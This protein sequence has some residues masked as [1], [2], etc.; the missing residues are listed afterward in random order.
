MPRGRGI[1][2]QPFQHATS[3]IIMGAGNGLRL[4]T[5]PRQ[6]CI[7]H[8]VRA[9]VLTRQCPRPRSPLREFPPTRDTPRSA[10][11]PTDSEGD[12]PPLCGDAPRRHGPWHHGI[13]ARCG[14]SGKASPGI[15]SPAIYPRVDH[16]RSR[17]L[18][19]PGFRWPPSVCV[20]CLHCRPGFDVTND[21][22]QL[23]GT[24]RQARTHGSQTQRSHRPFCVAKLRPVLE[25]LPRRRDDS[26]GLPDADPRRQ[27]PDFNRS[28]T[29]GVASMAQ[30]LLAG[31]SLV[32][33]EPDLG[34]IS[35]LV[36]RADA[37]TRTGLTLLPPLPTYILE[38]VQARDLLVFDRNFTT[39]G[40]AFGIAEPGSCFVG[41]KHQRI[42]LSSPS[43]NWSSRGD[44]DGQ[45]LRADR[46]PPIPTPAS[47]RSCGAS[48]SASSRRRR[49]REDNWALDQ[50]ASDG[51]GGCHR[52]D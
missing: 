38:R 31:K 12:S 23:P 35:D 27:C 28:S 6:G 2:K 51:L 26:C 3:C 50:F 9:R 16:R 49:R 8:Y 41:R 46:A 10:T 11:L 45:D 37:Y 1:R 14:G 48:R 44:G 20:R 21:L 47:R 5:S 29:H 36:L 19:H 52:R 32:V 30:R 15:C 33:F 42:C 24:R 7:N 39:T 25:K 43:A 4:S 13:A 17:Q 34:L 18:A 22:H 40:F